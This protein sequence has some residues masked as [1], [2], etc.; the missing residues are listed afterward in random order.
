MGTFHT[1][2]KRYRVLAVRNPQDQAFVKL[3]V[4]ASLSGLFAEVNGI[5]LYQVV[6]A[7]F[8]KALLP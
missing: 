3:Q 8:L 4:P 5:R 2:K 1:W 7:D 6:S